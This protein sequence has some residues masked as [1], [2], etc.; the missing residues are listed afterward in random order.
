MQRIKT[1]FVFAFMTTIL[2]GAYVVLYKPVP[3]PPA[4]VQSVMDAGL[5]EPDIGFGSE[6]SPE[7]LL[8]NIN[9]DSGSSL[10]A[11]DGETIHIGSAE[12]EGS[13][14]SPAE[15]LNT[16]ETAEN[17]DDTAFTL[18]DDGA[19]SG[20]ISD[21]GSA[22]EAESSVDTSDAVTTTD[23]GSFN[24]SSNDG[25]S[26]VSDSGTSTNDST[27][28]VSSNS[29]NFNPDTTNTDDTFQVNKDTATLGTPVFDE[30]SV[31]PAN[32]TTELETPVVADANEFFDAWMS[33]REQVNNGELKAALKKL[34][35]YQNN[36]SVSESHHQQLLST[37]DYL[38][39]EVIYSRN[40]HLQPAHLVKDG[41]TVESI[42]HQFNVPATLLRNINGFRPEVQPASG[43]EIKVMQG[44]FRA[45][46]SLTTNELTLFLDDMYAGR[47]TIK[48]GTSPAPRAGTFQ[49]QAK[50]LDRSFI[51]TTGQ[52]VPGGHEANPYG[53]FWLD[54]GGNLCIHGQPEV[55]VTA[56][57]P[58]GCIQLGKRDAADMFGILSTGSKVI[59][60]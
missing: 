41:E 35:A 25:G 46:V 57:L 10:D 40:H 12:D 48:V 14:V 34:S 23:D 55:A 29:S 4:E 24:V 52:V 17:S 43:D 2:Y 42:A 22:A 31:T 19:A 8:A 36:S 20:S 56:Q 38:A 39:A 54:L 7:D 9:E 1:I 53:A 6:V 11:P 51:T 5:P 3:A 26:T 13:F 58:V 27:F 37:L 16:T 30:T 28:Q 50:Q 18:N 15:D 60:R 21:F 33:A 49:V 44:P 32:N 45:E 59:I 47:F